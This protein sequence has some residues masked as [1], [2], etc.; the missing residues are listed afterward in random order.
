[1]K[2]K[3]V[4]IFGGTFNPPHIGHVGAAKAFIKAAALDKLVIMPDN[5]PPHK[6]LEGA[7]SPIDRFVMC[8]RAFFNV[9]GAEISDFEILNGGKSYTVITLETFSNE[10]TELFFLCGT[11]MFI[12]LKSWYNFKRIFELCTICLVRREKDDEIDEKLLNLKNEYIESFNARIIDVPVDVV[13]ISSSEIRDSLKNREN[14]GYLPENVFEYIIEK[15]L[16]L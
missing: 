13:D 8:Q 11:D 5:L 15:E 14:L 1:M 9:K 6:Q 3:R 7:T 4:G 16:Y 12:T 10:D 2:K